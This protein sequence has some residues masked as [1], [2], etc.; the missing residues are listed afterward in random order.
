[1]LNYIKSECYRISHQ[2]TLYITTGILCS[3]IIAII[4]FLALFGWD[5]YG[6]DL[7]RT[8]YAYTMPISSP[9]CYLFM[10]AVIP[11]LIYNCIHK[12]GDV[13][14]TVAGGLSRV[15]IF[16][17]KCITSL[18]AASVVLA[19]VLAVWIASAELLLEPGGP[20]TARDLLLE[21]P[22]VYLIAAANVITVQL[23]FECFRKEL[24]V[25]LAWS[26]IWLI[27]PTVLSAF[28]MRFDLFTDIANWMPY[29]FFKNAVDIS[30][31]ASGEVNN[32]SWSI[33]VAEQ[34]GTVLW[35][36]SEGLFKCLISGAIGVAVFS[37]SGWFI[38][39][40]RDL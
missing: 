14:N 22:A 23:F 40:R 25:A 15:Q 20:F 12:Y 32:I 35:Y 28:G 21:V 24:F 27:L 17:G 5:Q 26:T 19:V 33:N 4:S 13:K 37:L 38:L 11:A 31:L 39:R 36:T 3:L 10:A 9:S 8:G 34:T 29:Q 16:A 1:M 7:A 6:L 18:I 30:T 2:P